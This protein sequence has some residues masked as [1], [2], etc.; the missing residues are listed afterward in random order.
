MATTAAVRA[1]FISSPRLASARPTTAES[2]PSAS[3]ARSLAALAS[4]SG[5]AVP[6]AASTFSPLH[7]AAR[8]LRPEVLGV[9]NPRQA[10]RRAA[11]EVDALLRVV[12]VVDGERARRLGSAGTM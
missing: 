1:G 12:Q 5:V 6:V 3:A 8:R 4:K 7:A 9:G 2:S 10:G 11:A